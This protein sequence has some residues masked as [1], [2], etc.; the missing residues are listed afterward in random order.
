MNK[1][2]L[3]AIKWLDDPESVSEDELSEAKTLAY[4]DYSNAPRGNG[5][6]CALGAIQR[7]LHDDHLSVD[8]F[9]DE[10]F[11]LTGE[12][13]EEYEKELSM[14]EWTIYNNESEWQDLSNAQ[15][16]LFLLHAHEGGDTNFLSSTGPM[17]ITGSSLWLCVNVYQAVKPEP[18]LWEVFEKD[19]GECSVGGKIVG[20]QMIA[21]G[22]AKI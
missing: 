11:E 9:V 5:E 19:W 22:W 8:C 14:E 3:L 15:K 1:A 10:Y 13:R 21:K 4:D 17:S 6:H 16:G 2:I 20:K 7:A 18:E 12:N